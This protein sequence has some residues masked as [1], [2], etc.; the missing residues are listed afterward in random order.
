[1]FSLIQLP[2]LILFFYVSLIGL[3]NLFS[4]LFKYLNI[5]NIFLLPFFGF[6]L[7][8][9]ISTIVHFF[10]PL[11]SWLNLIIWITGF[12]NFFKI[13]NDKKYNIYFIKE[14]K[15]VFF[16]LLVLTTIQF[17]HH[18]VNEDFGYYHL[19]YIQNF[20]SERII[21]GLH[22]LS[23]VQGYNSGWLNVTSVF[24]MPF[25]NFKTIHFANSV[26]NLSILLFVFS[27]LFKIK[28]KISDN[29]LPFSYC[30][31]LIF[32]ILS[33]YSRLNSFGLDVPGQIFAALTF[34]FFLIFV[35]INDKSNQIKYFL[36]ISIF[37]IFSFLIKLSY[38]ALLIFPLICI[39]KIK[40]I[41]QFLK[42][43]ISILIKLS[44]LPLAWVCQQVVYT[45]C[46]IFPVSITC[47][48]N[49]E[50][51]S[52]YKTQK[53]AFSLEYINKSF[54]SYKGIL[55]ESEYIKNLNWVTTWYQR[56][57]IELFE[58]IF[59]YTTPILFLSIYKFIKFKFFLEANKKINLSLFLILIIPLIVGYLIWFLKA[60]VI[61]YGIFY[62]YSIIFLIIYF[63]FLVKLNFK[64]FRVFLI[65]IALAGS[66]N[67][68][69][70][71]NRIF[72]TQKNIFSPWPEFP[73]INYIS[74]NLKNNIKINVPK[75][76]NMPK[77]DYCWDT[78]SLCKINDYQDIKVR[79]K[80]GYF[81]ILQKN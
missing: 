74:Y 33:K 10:S 50:W 52:L 42:K 70:N 23:M 58:N 71:I 65:I 38:I 36:I 13:L 16:L 21:F 43:N 3:G 75:Q 11:Y 40:N 54:W 64:N 66:F 76:Y 46:I 37:S 1:M 28:N 51:F 5:K 26:L 22:N 6:V 41:N 27:Y 20:V 9:F 17:I 48:G 31:L 12:L 44:L 30:F 53:A 35:G 63:S 14:N 25:Y 57:K 2:F 47:F 80:N 68:S 69:K 19:P 67:I 4:N 62:L 55:T 73:K 29:L 24:Y 61:R 81:F 77:T 79:K 34:I 78:P 56:N 45:G 49:L 39:I 72:D 60:P 32:F 59:T 7:L 8:F 18:N 15:L